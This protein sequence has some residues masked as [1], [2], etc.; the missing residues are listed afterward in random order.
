MIDLI[1]AGLRMQVEYLKYK[2]FGVLMDNWGNASAAFNPGQ[3][4]IFGTHIMSALGSWMGDAEEDWPD[5]EASAYEDEVMACYNGE[6]MERAFSDTVSRPVQP[7]EELIQQAQRAKERAD[8]LEA[9]GE[10]IG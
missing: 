5:A 10:F 1:V 4:S 9:A 2:T 8:F 7:M 3:Q 6:V